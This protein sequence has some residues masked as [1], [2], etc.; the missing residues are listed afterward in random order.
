MNKSDFISAIGNRTLKKDAEVK[1]IIDAAL[2]IIAEQL[3]AGEPV[4]LLGFGRFEVRTHAECM[5]RNP[6]TG[7]EVE[8][9][10]KKVPAFKAAKDLKDAVK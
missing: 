7:E 3:K 9:P 2:T 4:T 5:R 6:R 1:P 8:V 10:A